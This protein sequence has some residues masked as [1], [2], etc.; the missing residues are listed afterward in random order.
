[1]SL[2]VAAIAAAI[3][4]MPVAAQTRAQTPTPRGTP[5]LGLP[6]EGPAVPAQAAGQPQ[7]G[8]AAFP[9][10]IRPGRTSLRL[11]PSPGIPPPVIVDPPF[12]PPFVAI[13]TRPRRPQHHVVVIQPYP[14]HVYAPAVAP[15]PPT[16][17]V[18]TA[19]VEPVQPVPLTGRELADALLHWDEPE[20][21]IAAYQVHLAENPDDSEALRMLGMALIDARRIPEGVAAIALAHERHPELAHSPVPMDV[22]GPPED[23]RRNLNRVSVHAN[24]VNTASA[25]LAL[26]VLMQAE[27]RTRPA[28]AMLARAEESGLSDEVAREM[29]S[30]VGSGQAAARPSR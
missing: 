2:F 21:A 27:G 12:P 1:M 9:E 7:P 14:H 23:L 16:P 28:A 20:R 29:R 26:A 6:A 8:R 25:W 10:P 19:T 4:T 13:T 11:P 24:R 18:P 30:V 17:L 3:A 22:F 5:H 15:T